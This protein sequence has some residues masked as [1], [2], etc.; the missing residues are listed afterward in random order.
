MGGAS[1]VVPVARSSFLSAVERE[2]GQRIMDC[3]QCGKCTAGCPASASADLTPRRVMRGIQ[4][5]LAGEVMDS[6][7]IWICLSCQTC[8]AR[9]PCEIDI[10]RVME[11]LRLMATREGRA[12]ER[13]IALFHR[14]FLRSVEASGRLWELGLGGFYNLSSGHPFANLGLLPSLFARG[15]LD[16]LPHQNKN[17]QAAVKRIF[18]R[19]SQLEGK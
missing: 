18:E 8:T 14:L 3:Y 2:S 11:S 9:C 17:A 7:M 10:A 13:D 6:S 15:K 1:P 5:G 4:L 16:I 12:R 19:V